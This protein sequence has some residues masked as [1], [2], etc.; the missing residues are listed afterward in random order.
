MKTNGTGATAR[1]WQLDALRGLIMM[2]MALDHAN[3]FVAQAH[4]PGEYWGGPMPAYPS[5]LALLTRLV[6]HLCAPG[7]FFLMGIS[8]VLFTDS[9]LRRGWGERAVTVHFLVRGSLLIA[10]QFLVVNRAWELSPG[11][12]TPEVYAGV[13]FALGSAMIAGSGLR[14]LRPLPL[15]SLAVI[16][17]IATEVLT[18]APAHWGRSYPPLQHLLVLPGGSARLWVNYPLL[19]WLPFV[20]FGLMFG[21]R[22]LVD[23]HGVLKGGLWM[24]AGLL[25]AFVVVRGL[26]GF[27]NVRPRAGDGWVDVLNVIKYPPSLSFGLLTMGLNL[28]ILGGLGSLGEGAAPYLQPL[29]GFG[30]VPL[31]FYLLHLFGYAGFGGWLTPDGTS[32]GLMYGYWLAG[33]ALLYPVCVW[34]GRL[35]QRRPGSALLRFV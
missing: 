9:R 19:P 8:V 20:T 21:R 33:L 5:D 3:H 13:L 32:L 27:G 15:L 6:T 25:V 18:P 34:Y 26:D 11:G 7:F 35:K 1:L 23:S 16:L 31:L 4:S 28:M 12:W 30:R 10:L 17:L 2:L 29:M 14:L 22:L 24:G